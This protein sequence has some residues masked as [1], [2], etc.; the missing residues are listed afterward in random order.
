MLLNGRTET[1]C[2]TFIGKGGS[3]RGAHLAPVHRAAARYALGAAR[4]A[5]NLPDFALWA[6]ARRFLRALD[7]VAA[8]KHTLVGA[9]Q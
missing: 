2:G 9:F 5:N 3:V 1:A 7:S 8:D 4:A 6:S